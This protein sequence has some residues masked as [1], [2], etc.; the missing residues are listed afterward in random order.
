MFGERMTRRELKRFRRHGLDR[1]A[2]RL[3]EALAEAAPLE[4]AT[5]LEI[6]AGIGGLSLALLERGV[7]RATTIDAAP[8]T[9]AVARALAAERGVADRLD[10]RVGDFAEQPAGDRYD[11]VVLDRVVCCYPD[12][13][14]LLAPAAG[15]ARRAIAMTYP[16][17]VWYMR[18]FTRVLNA[19]MA[20][21][22][23][24]YRFY[25]HPAPAMR[26]ELRRHGLEPRVAGHEFVWELL[27]AVRR[28]PQAGD[29]AAA[30]PA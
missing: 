21:L 26:E 4:R 24:Q 25:I 3:V 15:T 10:V 2:R 30:R 1:R 9:A 28:T 18:L 6:G 14:A 27:V 22:R 12:W 13:R 5:T 20:A 23:R 29:E 19:T 17:N 7:A 11:A 8:A 16:R